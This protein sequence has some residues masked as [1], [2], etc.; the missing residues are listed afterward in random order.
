MNY[1]VTVWPLMVNE[2]RKPKQT[3]SLNL[4]HFKG[5][6]ISNDNISITNQVKYCSGK[7]F[8]AVIVFACSFSQW[9]FVPL[10]YAEGD[11]IIGC[12]CKLQPLDKS[13][14]FT[15]TWLATLQFW[16][17]KLTISSK[18]IHSKKMYETAE[19]PL[20]LFESHCLM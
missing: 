15:H 12:F 14:Q 11:K 6:S 8:F 2:N 9:T 3:E 7:T 13:R 18:F 10:F 17:K 16:S 20:Q 1:C 5:T 4:G 19:S